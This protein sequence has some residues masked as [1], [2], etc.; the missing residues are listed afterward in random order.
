[1]ESSESSKENQEGYSNLTESMHR[2]M[3]NVTNVTLKLSYLLYFTI[4]LSVI[5]ML[6]ISFEKLTLVQKRENMHCLF[7]FLERNDDWRKE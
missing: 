4:V 1:M 2:T 6:I 5:I 3:I 7:A